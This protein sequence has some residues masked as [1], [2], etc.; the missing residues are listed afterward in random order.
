MLTPGPLPER[1]E[2]KWFRCPQTGS[3]TGTTSGAGHTTA[4]RAGPGA[5]G[6][7]R[8]EIEAT[9][10]RITGRCR[11]AQAGPRFFWK[12]A[13]HQNIAASRKPHGH[14][15]PCVRTRD[16][17]ETGA[18]SGGSFA[19]RPRR[20]VASVTDN[21]TSPALS[22]A[23]CP[24]QVEH[25]APGLMAGSIAG[26]TGMNEK[27]SWDAVAGTS[28]D[29]GKTAPRPRWSAYGR[30]VRADCSTTYRRS[31]MYVTQ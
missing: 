17:P 9:N 10:V 7:G 14:L 21:P 13:L 30:A 4:F 18:A 26:G 28:A 27:A 16:N 12:R 22:R 29:V 3:R 24:R 8:D 1:D 2:V 15:P 20:R 31:H 5:A 11:P 25:G 6:T 23:P 19:P